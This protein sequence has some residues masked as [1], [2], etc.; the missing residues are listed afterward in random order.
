MVSTFQG[1]LKELFTE[2]GQTERV[3]AVSLFRWIYAPNVPQQS[4]PYGDCGPW[5]CKFLNDLV[6]GEEPSYR[7]EET[8]V[9]CLAWRHHMAD[10]FWGFR[11]SVETGSGSG[12]GSSDG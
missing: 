1:R 11:D 10:V 3:E 9:D 6:N 4:G 8:G 7:G 12:S 5:V 2:L